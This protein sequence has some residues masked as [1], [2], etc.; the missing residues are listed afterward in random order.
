[1]KV[2]ICGITVLD[3]A[4]CA[5]EAGADMLGFNFWGPSPRCVEPDA[6]RVLGEMLPGSIRKVGVFVDA[7]ADEVKQTMERARLDIAQLHGNEP[8]STCA[9]V[10]ARRPMPGS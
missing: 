10:R 1:M 4:L 9:A 7:S 5:V 2:K 6:V 8:P 3:D